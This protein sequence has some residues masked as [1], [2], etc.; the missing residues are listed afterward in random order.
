MCSTSGRTAARRRVDGCAIGRRHRGP[1][2]SG[3]NCPRQERVG[4]CRVARRTDIDIN[5]LAVLVDRSKCV[6]PTA[7]DTNVGF[8]ETPAL[9]DTATAWGRRVLIQRGVPPGPIL[10]ANPK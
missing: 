2:C 5:D 9:A 1:H 4:R 6:A 3:L 10:L 7:G 8:I